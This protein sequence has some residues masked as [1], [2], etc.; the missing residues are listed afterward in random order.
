MH[1]RCLHKYED[2]CDRG[3]FPASLC[4]VASHR[5]VPTNLR[6]AALLV[7]KTLV[8]EG[9]SPSLD[10]FQGEV[11]VSET[12]KAPLR[13]ALLAIATSD[14]DD[15][16]VKSAASYVVSK[17]ASSD[18]PE[19]W[20]TLLPTLLHLISTGTQSQAHGALKVLRDLVE[21]GLSD[22][23]F[24]GVA[25]DLVKVVYDT[26][27]NGSKKAT[28]RALA[29]SVFR[30]CFDILEMVK[31]SHRVAVKTFADEALTAW[32]PFFTDVLKQSLG[33]VP[34]GDNEATG[35][36]GPEEEWR[37]LIALKLQVV[38][39]LMK[40]KAVFPGLLS[41]HTPQLFSATWQ[42]LSSLQQPYHQ[43]YV[44][45]ERQ[46]R[47]V[48]ADGLPYTLDLLVLEELDFMQS[49]LRAP[50]VR[51]QL[52]AELRPLGEGHGSNSSWLLELIRLAVAYAQITT[53]EEGLWEIDVNIFL[54]EETSA[55]AN[56]TARTACGDLMT[57]LGDWLHEAA[58]Q[59][60]QRHAS[61]VFAS[62]QSTWKEKEAVLFLLH[63]L[64]GEFNDISRTLSQNLAHSFA[65]SVRF[66]VQQGDT[67]LRARG[68]LVYG[69]LV[70]ASGEY[71]YEAGA[72]FVE[73][74]L[75]AVT[76]DSSEVVKVACVRVLQDFLQALPPIMMQ[77]LQGTIFSTL[78]NFFSA[79]DPSELT[80][81]DELVVALTETLR[82]TIALDTLICIAADSG[83]LNLLFSVASRAPSNF[84]LNMLVSETFEDI[85]SQV[86]KAG[87]GAYTRLC[88]IVL[89]SLTGAFD[90]GN[91]T[92]ENALT[93][94][95]AD[96]LV[97]L[98]GHGFEPLPQ[99]F[100]A[101]V[102]PKLECLLLTSTDGEI[103][104]PGTEAIK[105]M[106]A[107][108]PLQVFEWHDS[109]G[110]SGLEICL[111]LIDRLLQQGIDDNAAAEVGGLAAE[112]VEKAGSE[113]L[114][115]Y[116]LQLLRAVTIRLESA[117]QAAFIQSLILVFA[118]LSLVSAKDV[119]D[120]LAQTENGLQVVMSKWLENSVTFAGYDEIRQ[121]VIAL[122]KL[123]ALNDARL[124]TTM[125]KGDLIIPVSNRI[126][127]RSR[128][129]QTPDQF[130]TVS[131]PVKIIKVLIEE[132]T[133][134]SGRSGSG[135]LEASGASLVPSGMA[136]GDNQ[137]GDPHQ[138][139]QPNPHDP[140]AAHNSNSHVNNNNINHHHPISRQT[141]DDDDDDFADDDDDEW[142]DAADDEVGS[143]SAQ[144]AAAAALGGSG[145]LDLGLSSTKEALMGFDEARLFALRRRDDETQAYLIDF[146]RDVEG[147]DVGGFREIYAHALTSAE[148]SR[149]MRVVGA[150]HR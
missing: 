42:E 112:L 24:F 63:Q 58:A 33:P 81:S 87:S 125:V 61:Q 59:D 78:S 88:G 68:Y 2:L 60:L 85:T 12:T 145:T 109:S 27:I 148:Q 4:S 147:R 118:R 9:W 97:I 126:M 52:Q 130:T 137:A 79:Q 135:Q 50:P 49:C 101:T 23:Q 15:R 94:L 108:D 122:S 10:E 18:F 117:E 57:K 111:L 103:L 134:A 31:D 102:M 124:A 62:A 28:L 46:S 90:V 17:I 98:A 84:Q 36:E 82:D 132:L 110:K 128:A 48:D 142:E 11:L 69:G 26:A 105:N 131:V 6:Q 141:E 116:L 119:V 64:L 19:Q 93:V 66:A 74:I 22:D 1:W 65:E 89:P 70:K 55:T 72:A 21:E 29:V 115:P 45:D 53:E 150:Q 120:F 54:S 140:N 146:F 8:V 43:L 86:T 106:L 3:P 40:I 73:Q 37:G 113:R 75:T 129:K 80:D 143:G 47:L 7:L 32:L 56:Y 144:A 71:L 16:K 149:L 92:G 41:P 91:L 133:S 44:N 30:G 123:Y 96:L 83:A 35:G 136:Q 107:H 76:N 114:G 100:V 14:E 104:R 127:T 95:A 67:F 51:K 138:L 25:R 38:K 13:E 99:G 34:Q 139:S 20:P 121:N 5:S 77:P 39:T